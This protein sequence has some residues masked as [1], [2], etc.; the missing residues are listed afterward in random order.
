MNVVTY[1]GLMDSLAQASEWTIALQLLRDMSPSDSHQ[2]I[3][4]NLRRS[5]HE[6]QRREP[7]R[8]VSA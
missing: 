6:S 1:N 8:G 2:G 7:Q 3:V 5:A 4:P